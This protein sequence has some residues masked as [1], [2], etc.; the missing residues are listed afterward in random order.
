MRKVFNRS[1]VAHV[2]AS[3]HQDE[4]RTGNGSLY[5]RG[6]TIYSYGSHFP[7]AR[8][9][10]NKQGASAVFFTRADY[11]VTT[12]SHKSMVRRAC[13]H[14]QVFHVCNPTRIDHKANLK[15]YREDFE[16]C[17]R[18]YARA[19]VHKQWALD[20]MERIVN[21]SNDYAE[22]FGLKTRLA[23]P[24]NLEDMQAE[25]CRLD[26]IDREHKQQ[27][28][29]ERRRI[30]ENRRNEDL[31]ALQN[32]VDGTSDVSCF[33]YDMP[34]R[35]RIKGDTLETSRGA[36]VPLDH[37]IKAFRIMR[38]IRE[39]GESWHRNGEEIRL[40]HFHIDSINGEG[41]VKAG[42]HTVEWAEI[43]RVAALAGV[44]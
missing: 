21:E 6:D 1:M 32:W 29:E 22:F 9:V 25:C 12:A 18:E 40:G 24:D 8:H 31:A 15:A 33:G 2:W 36:T 3:Q 35:L 34:T 19:R 11:S 27:A 26:Q 14:K 13:S 20:R 7:I 41:I 16:G 39:R 10:R 17:K 5:F 43:E 23:M 44:L 28:R 38:A 42:C 30:A 37:A 4:G